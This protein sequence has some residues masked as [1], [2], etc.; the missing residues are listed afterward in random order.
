[1]NIRHPRLPSILS[2]SAIQPRR[3]VF[4]WYLVFSVTIPF[5]SHSKLL[6]LLESCTHCPLRSM[7]SWWM[8]SSWFRWRHPLS[9][10]W[11]PCLLFLLRFRL[12]LRFWRGIAFLCLLVRSL[13]GTDV[14]TQ[15]RLWLE[16]VKVN[17]LLIL[18]ND[19]VMR[20]HLLC[21]VLLQLLTAMK[22]ERDVP[23]STR[24][25]EEANNRIRLLRH[26]F[27]SISLV[28]SS[29]PSSFWMQPLLALIYSSRSLAS[30]DHGKREWVLDD[31]S[32]CVDS[33][34]WSP[35]WIPSYDNLGIS[36]FMSIQVN[37]LNNH[38]TD[39]SEVIPQSHHLSKWRKIYQWTS[40]FTLT[41]HC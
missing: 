37:T 22:G 18:N 17:Q 31:W 11:S 2:F 19:R 33:K 21:I 13:Q 14:I 26:T 1:M 35:N 27:Y 5:V 24:S 8:R 4:S 12:F 16:C 41:L 7:G 40:S 6:S 34:Q 20:C 29:L 32:E 39:T 28:W 3:S 36:T 30:K 9:F 38:W 23:E 25:N 10:E 15:Q